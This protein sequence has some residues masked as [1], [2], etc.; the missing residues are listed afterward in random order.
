[1][2]PKKYKEDIKREYCCSLDEVLP[3]AKRSTP[4]Q[5][6]DVIRKVPQHYINDILKSLRITTC[7]KNDYTLAQ[8]K[9]AAAINHLYTIDKGIFSYLDYATLEVTTQEEAEEW[10]VI[11]SLIYN[12]LPRISKKRVD[13]LRPEWRDAYDIELR[14][15]TVEAIEWVPS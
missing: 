5:V 13:E 4:L 2:R 12:N 1:M 6:V 10:S 15:Y 9:V 8:W 7:S 14:P 3:I 11:I